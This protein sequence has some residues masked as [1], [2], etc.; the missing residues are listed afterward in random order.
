MIDRSP[1]QAFAFGKE[2]NRKRGINRNHVY[3][4][5]NRRSATGE[6]GE[7]LLRLKDLKT[8]MVLQITMVQ[9]RMLAA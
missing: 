8:A 2:D 6:G 3:P 5:H 7:L 4:Y 1:G 9:A